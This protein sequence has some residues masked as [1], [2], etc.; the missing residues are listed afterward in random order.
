MDP[1]WL[2]KKDE[3]SEEAAN[4]LHFFEELRVLFASEELIQQFPVVLE[5]YQRSDIRRRTGESGLRTTRADFHI[6]TII[7][8]L[9]ESVEGIFVIERHLPPD[10]VEDR[11]ILFRALENAARGSG[12]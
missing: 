10:L 12:R 3:W 1:R 2:V 8:Y 6:R 9:E 5:Y 4:A 11:A 7:S